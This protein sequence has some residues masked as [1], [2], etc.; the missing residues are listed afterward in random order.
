MFFAGGALRQGIAPK[1]PTKARGSSAVR[2]RDREQRPDEKA[3]QNAHR[4][5]SRC[6]S[7]H[8]KSLFLDARE[9]LM[10]ARSSARRCASITQQS[11]EPL[12]GHPVLWGGGVIF[13]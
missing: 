8:C 6:S 13:V 10:R 4:S 2:K 7:R 9:D 3:E 12:N 1:T 11:D 5:G